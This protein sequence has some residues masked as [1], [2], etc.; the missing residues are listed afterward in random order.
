MKTVISGAILD[1]PDRSFVA[2]NVFGTDSP[3]FEDYAFDEVCTIPELHCVHGIREALDEA[4]SS[5]AG[6]DGGS[7]PHWNERGHAIAGR[8]ILE[9]LQAYHLVTPALIDPAAADPV[10]AEP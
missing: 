1:E 9:Y 8:V 7:D 2:F 5:G 6:V 4:R 10:G 3:E